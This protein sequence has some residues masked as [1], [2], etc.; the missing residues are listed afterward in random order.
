ML[1]ADNLAWKLSIVLK[2]H[3]IRPDE[4]LDSYE[5]EVN[6]TTK[7][8]YIKSNIIFVEKASSRRNTQKHRKRH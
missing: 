6:K 1:L 3:A 7:D 2:G 4:L 8:I 5:S